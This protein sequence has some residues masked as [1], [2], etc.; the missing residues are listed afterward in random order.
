MKSTVLRA[1]LKDT[2]IIMIFD[3]EVKYIPRI[4]LSKHKG[5]EVLFVSVLMYITKVIIDN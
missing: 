2:E 5:S 1:S 4:P 3:K